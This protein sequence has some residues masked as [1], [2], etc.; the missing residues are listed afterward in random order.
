MQ[1]LP[2][3]QVVQQVIGRLN[4]KNPQKN[5]RTSPRNSGHFC[6]Y[7]S[8]L[9]PNSARYLCI[10]N[11]GIK[12]GTYSGTS[13]NWYGNHP[14]KFLE[15]DHQQKPRAIRTPHQTAPESPT[16]THHKS[17][18]R[19]KRN[20]KAA[21]APILRPQS[22]DMTPL[23][24]EIRTLLTRLRRFRRVFSSL[25]VMRKTTAIKQP[26]N[27]PPDFTP[28][29]AREKTG[30]APKGYKSPFKNF[31]QWNYFHLIAKTMI[32]NDL[33]GFCKWLILWGCKKLRHK[34]DD[35]QW[36]DCVWR[37]KRNPK[38]GKG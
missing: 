38:W 4:S 27:K 33:G 8:G 18:A 24:D 10:K 20:F 29:G 23:R 21:H 37:N 22:H 17:T 11:S 32:S 3:L 13:P 30:A 14:Q 7:N 31:N 28:Q 1:K 2:L 26:S 34:I 35:L 5:V 15:K 12:C 36:S 19:F 25:L 9:F 16:Q 6:I